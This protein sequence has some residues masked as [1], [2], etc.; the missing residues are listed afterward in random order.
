MLQQLS[1]KTFAEFQSQSQHI[2][3]PNLVLAYRFYS[4]KNVTSPATTLFFLIVFASSR[5]F[6][7]FPAEEKCNTQPK[8]S[9]ARI[10]WREPAFVVAS[11]G[12][13]N[14]LERCCVRKKQTYWVNTSLE[15]MVQTKVTPVND[16]W[17]I[18]P[19]TMTKKLRSGIWI[20]WWYLLSLLLKKDWHKQE[21][22]HPWQSMTMQPRL[23]HAL[24]GLLSS[25]W[26]HMVRCSI[27]RCLFWKGFWKA[28]T[29]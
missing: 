21:H 22:N 23:G 24:L 11:T 3:L 9:Q 2:S 17:S 27:A 12:T 29:H 20:A 1:K 8:L 15:S 4:L 28:S 14:K 13:L 18:E 5:T 6:S 26:H 19:K 7:L 25:S 10:G 16:T